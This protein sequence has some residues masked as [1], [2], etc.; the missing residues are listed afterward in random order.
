MRI[1]NKIINCENFN[2]LQ[3]L[4]NVNVYNIKNPNEKSVISFIKKNKIK[5]S[6]S[7]TDH[8]F[9]SKILKIP[10]HNILNK[11]SSLLP[12]LKGLLP[13]FWAKIKKQN[14]GV[15]VHVVSNK[16]DSGKIVYQKKINKNFFS[17]VNF[18]IYIFKNYPYYI[19]KAIN[20]L[21][22][23]KFIKNNYESSYYS[24]PDIK[25][26]KLFLKNGGKVISFSDVYNFKNLI[27]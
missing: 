10:N 18:Y 13:Y 2:K 6:L 11:H 16:V 7:L 20:N 23:K 25:D 26:Y 12:S 1:K 24:L 19:L 4:T 21:K 3:T 9:G 8:I 14:N 22:K 5:Y 17:M 15:S 27:E